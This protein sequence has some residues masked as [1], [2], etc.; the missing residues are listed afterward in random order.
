MSAHRFLRGAFKALTSSLTGGE[1]VGI[2]GG[3]YPAI[4]EMSSET[5]DLVLGGDGDHRRLTAMIRTS[6]LPTIPAKGEVVHARD[7]D[8]IVAE[9]ETH[10]LTSTRLTLESPDRR[11]F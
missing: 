4:I 7:K 2:G 5:E 3:S 9:V 1:T 6:A 10:P 8:W 11:E